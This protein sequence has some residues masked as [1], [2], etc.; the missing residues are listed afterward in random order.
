VSAF[1]KEVDN[2]IGKLPF[3]EFLF[4]RFK[5]F[6]IGGIYTFVCRFLIQTALLI[7]FKYPGH[8]NGK[9]HFDRYDN[10]MAQVKGSKTFT[11]FD[12]SQ[13][14][15]IY[16]GEHF[17]TATLEYGWDKEGKAHFLRFAI[18]SIR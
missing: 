14:A 2:D 6:W 15:L 16:G 4:P 3:S 5:L 9:L 17:D 18:H 1:D 12:P 11:L 7:S 10:L 13:S 8:T